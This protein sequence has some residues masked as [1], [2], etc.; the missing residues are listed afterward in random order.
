MKHI[1]HPSWQARLLPPASE[2]LA[3]QS[4]VECY[5]ALVKS[6]AKLSKRRL[7][8]THFY[9]MGHPSF[10]ALNQHEI[11]RCEEAS[12]QGASLLAEKLIQHLA[13]V[14]PRIHPTGD[15]THRL[16][17]GYD[18]DQ[19]HTLN[20]H[21]QQLRYSFHHMHSDVEAADQ[22]VADLPQNSH[23]SKLTHAADEVYRATLRPQLRRANI[24]MRGA[25]ETLEELIDHAPGS[26]NAQNRA[27]MALLKHCRQTLGTLE[28]MREHTAATAKS[29]HAL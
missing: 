22:L 4:P 27:E 7:V 25:L 9:N 28:A 26:H 21:V 3:Q 6:F 13:A 16:F 8:P 29:G 1:R 5:N 24:A 14:L 2:E 15:G 11:N 18:A 23:T 17:E 20:A 12:D 19:I 10:E